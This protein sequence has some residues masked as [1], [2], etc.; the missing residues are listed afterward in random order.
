M[1]LSAG[2]MRHPIE[3]QAPSV[4]QADDGGQRLAWTTV[5]KCW[6]QIT[7]TRESERIIAAQVGSRE[8]HRVCLRWHGPLPPTYRIVRLEDGR[9]LDPVSVRDVDERHE[10]YEIVCLEKTTGAQ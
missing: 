10:H 9:V 6:A 8:T 3:I 5:V 2:L 4:S 1:P 7:P